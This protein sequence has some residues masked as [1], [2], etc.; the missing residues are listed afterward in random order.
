MRN[1]REM[2]EKSGVLGEEEEESL[3]AVVGSR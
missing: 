2:D 3:K 1:S